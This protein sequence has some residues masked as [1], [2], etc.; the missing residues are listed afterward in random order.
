MSA[1][2]SN[3]QSVAGNLSFATTQWSVV[4]AAGEI[5]RHES[6]KALAVLC[7]DYWHPVYAY[8][9]RRVGHANDAQDL[10]QAFF[11]H[12]LDKQTIAGGYEKV[13]TAG[14]VYDNMCRCFCGAWVCP[15]HFWNFRKSRATLTTW[16]G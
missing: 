6:R 13:S 1:D 3:M 12:L 5:G 11:C 15:C 9:R 16:W 8:A 7:E 14:V 10:T 2:P 4:L